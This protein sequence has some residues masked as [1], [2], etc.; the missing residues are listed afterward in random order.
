M[1]I[2]ELGSLPPGTQVR[3]ILYDDR[4]HIYGLGDVLE[5]ELPTGLTIDVGWDE[6]STEGR[7]RIAVYREYFG[8][9]FVDFHV[10][11]VVDVVIE[12]QRLAAEWSQPC[13]VN[14]S[15][16]TEAAITL[17]KGAETGA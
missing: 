3:G 4:A 5:V 6:E 11:D 8:D 13:V 12:V 16:Q 9:R 2:V 14:S 17:P 15:A 1:K 10:R 7:F